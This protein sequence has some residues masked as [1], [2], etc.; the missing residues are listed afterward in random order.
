MGRR[1]PSLNSQYLVFSLKRTM[2][3]FNNF[4]CPGQSFTPCPDF[5]QQKQTRSDVSEPL[6][7]ES[8]VM[9]PLNMFPPGDCP[10]CL[11]S[12]LICLDIESTV[13][14]F[15]SNLLCMALNSV[16]CFIFSSLMSTPC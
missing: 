4:C 16:S 2:P 6:F 8:T 12:S 7:A 9:D 5:P 14:V 13:D 11:T 1:L 3:F 15:F 10:F